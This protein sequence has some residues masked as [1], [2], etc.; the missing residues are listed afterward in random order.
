M[1]PFFCRLHKKEGVQLSDKEIEEEANK[2]ELSHGG[3][4][5]RTARQ[6]ANY[7]AAKAEKK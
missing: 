3:L 5:G 6:F 2:W 7:M 1:H 4:S